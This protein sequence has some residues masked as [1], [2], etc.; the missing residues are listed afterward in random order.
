[1]DVQHNL[2]ESYESEV[3]VE[4]G[5]TCSSALDTLDGSPN[6]KAWHPSCGWGPGRGGHAPHKWDKGAGPPAHQ[7][8]SGA[9][10]L[11]HGRASSE[12]T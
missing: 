10:V 1:M 6:M 11:A 2:E 9:P 8:G 5:G 12:G 7:G 4:E 3:L